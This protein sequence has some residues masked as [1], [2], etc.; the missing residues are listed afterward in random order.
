MEV[1]H[2]APGL[3]RFGTHG[4]PYWQINRVSPGLWRHPKLVIVGRVFWRHSL[5]F[6]LMSAVGS[7]DV[8]RVA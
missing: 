1:E 6:N 3:S 4:S 2:P 5:S 8:P 7:T